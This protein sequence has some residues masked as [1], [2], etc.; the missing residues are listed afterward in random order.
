MSNNNVGAP[1]LGAFGADSRVFAAFESLQREFPGERLELGRV[2]AAS[3]EV[4][5]LQTAAG[6]T[7]GR[8]A[9]QL[10]AFGEL[11]VVGDWVACKS[12]G[13]AAASLVAF[14]PRRSQLS[15]KVAGREVREQV[16]AANVDVALLVMGLDQDYN[17]SRLERYSVMA[18][19]SGAEPVAVLTKADLCADP[20]AALLEVESLLPGVSA[21][22]LSALAGAGLDGLD[23]WLLPGRTL[24]L[25]GSSGAG[26][27]TL[28]NAL[29]GAAKLSTG[30]VRAKDGRGRH[31]TTRRELLLLPGGALLL[32]NPGLREIQLWAEGEDG[33][34]EAFEDIAA[35]ARQC[36]FSDC[37]HQRE[38]G[39]AVAAALHDGRL[40]R[41]RLES[42]F[43]LQR[44]LRSLELRQDVVARRRLERGFGLLSRQS[45]EAKRQ[46]F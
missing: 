12:A 31:T 3:R 35:L 25:L 10:R 6:E 39:C 8:P 45:Q 13:P 24:A 17:L 20:A 5:L 16:V 44:E 15:R 2:V 11:P 32:D 9:G 27:S 26:K 29:L 1:G 34:D 46:R 22:A 28:A 38:P 21:V 18:W 33:L 7:R 41:R 14:L 23:R 36:R 19:E 37:A 30:A 43:K 4:Y 42:Y 40:E